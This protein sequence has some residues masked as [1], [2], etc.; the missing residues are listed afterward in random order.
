MNYALLVKRIE[1]CAVLNNAIQ[2]MQKETG[3]MNLIVSDW[4]DVLMNH[5]VY[6]LHKDKKV[7]YTK[8][9][10]V[11]QE[12]AYVRHIKH[13]HEQFNIIVAGEFSLSQKKKVDGVSIVSRQ[14]EPLTCIGQC[15]QEAPDWTL[16]DGGRFFVETCEPRLCDICMQLHAR[17]NIPLLEKNWCVRILRVFDGKKLQNDLTHRLQQSMFAMKNFMAIFHMQIYSRMTYGED[18]YKIGGGISKMIVFQKSVFTSLDNFD[19]S[20]EKPLLSLEYPK[21]EEVI[22]EKK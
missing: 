19:L 17:E 12:K 11:A 3:A 6:K 22:E 16:H 15:M 9:H 14:C 7:K 20:N 13:Y 18:A 21:I 10:P 2:E 8:G 1:E 4:K 5:P